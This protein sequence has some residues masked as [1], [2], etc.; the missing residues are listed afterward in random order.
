MLFMGNDI[1]NNIF[2]INFMID[3]GS[4]VGV[5]GCFFED[6]EEFKVV[7]IINK[8]YLYIICGIGI[9]GNIV[10]FVIVWKM[11]LLIFF[12]IFMIV[13]VSMDILILVIKELYY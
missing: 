2:L 10:V 8:Y 5:V 13:L 12:L 1:D 4:I 7:F 3:C 6:F 11:K 9:F